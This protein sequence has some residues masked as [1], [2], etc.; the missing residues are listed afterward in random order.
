MASKLFPTVARSAR[1]FA[2]QVLRPQW[3]SFSAGPQVLSD[4]LAVVS[5]FTQTSWTPLRSL[6]ANAGIEVSL[7]LEDL[8]YG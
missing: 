3:R 1:Q 6:A 5:N 2:P 8:H 4:T 7:L